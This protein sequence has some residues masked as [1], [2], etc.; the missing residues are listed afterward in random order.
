MEG[1]EKQ[2][3]KKSS[4]VDYYKPPSKNKTQEQLPESALEQRVKDLEK[5]NQILREDRYD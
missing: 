2:S 3:D 1:R 4:F 5:S